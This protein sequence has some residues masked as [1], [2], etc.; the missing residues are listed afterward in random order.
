MTRKVVRAPGNRPSA[1]LPL[2]GVCDP[3]GSTLCSFSLKYSV[4]EFHADSYET[5]QQK[6]LKLEAAHVQTYSHIPNTTT[7]WQNTRSGQQ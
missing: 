6:F 3:K 4:S 1:R 2:G 5:Q 7:K